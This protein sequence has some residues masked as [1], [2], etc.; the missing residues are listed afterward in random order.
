MKCIVFIPLA[1]DRLGKFIWKI[2]L[3][4][5]VRSKVVSR[6]LEM[7]S[8]LEWVFNILFTKTMKNLKEKTNRNCYGDFYHS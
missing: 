5:I 2:D 1:C 7:E 3:A 8:K 6:S 4:L